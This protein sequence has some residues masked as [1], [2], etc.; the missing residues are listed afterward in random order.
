MIFYDIIESMIKDVNFT[1]GIMT[2][3]LHKN[4]YRKMTCVEG[5]D[6]IKWK[7]RKNNIQNMFYIEEL[8]PWYQWIKLWVEEKG[9]YTFWLLRDRRYT[10]GVR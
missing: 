5:G 7:K 4:K 1:F 10:T 8:Y 6:M 9:Y 3:I 2:I